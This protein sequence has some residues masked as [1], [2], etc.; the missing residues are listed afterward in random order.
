MWQTNARLTNW[1]NWL[2][3]RPTDRATHTQSDRRTQSALLFCFIESKRNCSFMLIA[4]VLLIRSSRQILSIYT[5]HNSGLSFSST[6]MGVINQLKT[7]LKLQ[8]HYTI[9]LVAWKKWKRATNRLRCLLYNVYIVYCQRAIHNHIFAQWGACREMG[10]SIE[11]LATQVWCQLRQ[12]NHWAVLFG[13]D[14]DLSR[15]GIYL[16]I[17]M[18]QSRLSEDLQSEIVRHN[19]HW[20]ILTARLKQVTYLS[21][22]SG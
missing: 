4:V 22:K 14:Y 2:R 19:L 7:Q 12:S 1:R 18:H 9:N 5:T 16:F 8:L 21:A 15:Q 10:F 17:N 20:N 6:S 3:D 11:P 13:M